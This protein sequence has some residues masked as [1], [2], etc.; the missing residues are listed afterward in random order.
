[1]FPDSNSNNQKTNKSKA[2]VN[3]TYI[4]KNPKSCRNKAKWRDLPK[5]S[6]GIKNIHQPPGAKAVLI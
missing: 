2:Y 1:M 6:A 5:L 3:S 4:L